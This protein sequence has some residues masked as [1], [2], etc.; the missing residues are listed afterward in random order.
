MENNVAIAWGTVIENVIGSDFD[1][2]IEGNTADNE[3]KGGGGND[4]LDG[5]A[6]S[7]RLYGGTH[8]DNISGGAG[9]DVIY[10]GHGADTLDGGAGTDAVQY[11][12]SGTGVTVNLATG[13][14]SAGQARGDV[15]S[16]IENINGSRAS[17]HLIGD[18]GN[19]KFVG[20]G[21]WD[22]LEGGAGDDRLEGWRG[23]D[24][25]DGGDGDDYLFGGAD[26]DTLTGGAGNDTLV[27]GTEGDLFIFEAGSGEDVITDFEADLDRLDLSATAT[28]FTDLASLQAATS[29]VDGGILIDLGGGDTL[30][31]QGLTLSD[32]ATTGIMY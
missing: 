15:L 9:N 16:N 19:N 30:L 24:V 12:A 31:L 23:K 21:G 22:T 27:G 32:L 25:L 8:N 18:D 10:G 6:G 26:E 29:E 4:T 5:G 20:Y 13:L 14:G 28:D 3:L 17:D 1:D 7:D 2:I 11:L